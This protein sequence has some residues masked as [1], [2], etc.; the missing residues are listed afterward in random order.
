MT[1]HRRSTAKQKRYGLKKANALIDRKIS[2]STKKALIKIK[3]QAT[4]K[5]PRDTQHKYKQKY[6]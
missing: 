4:S 3:N 2:P 5:P 1:K 6:N